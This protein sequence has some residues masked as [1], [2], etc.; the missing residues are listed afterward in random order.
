M[1]TFVRVTSW[2]YILIATAA[3]GALARPVEMGLA[4]VAGS[5]ALAF[6]YIDKIQKFKGAGFEAEMRQAEV[7]MAIVAKDAEP[8]RKSAASPLGFMVRAFST[9][10]E[11]DKVIRALG[12]GKYTWRSVGGIA[13]TTQLSTERVAQA[14]KWLDENDL[15]TS[16]AA[17]QGMLWGL[18]EEG[19]FLLDNIGATNSAGK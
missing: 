8:P 4:I 15:V 2:L 18:T 12:S 9:D 11:T 1:L 7:V 17:R 10:P 13:E 19:R 5:I 16:T 3:F 14:L 6:S